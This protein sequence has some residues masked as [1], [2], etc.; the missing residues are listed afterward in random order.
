MDSGSDTSNIQTYVSIIYIGYVI[1]AALSLF[2]KD[3]VGRQWSYRLYTLLWVV[4]QMAAC[5]TPTMRGIIGA[6]TV[7]G[8]GIGS[9][10]V[11]GPMS[12][13]EIS[14]KEIRGLLTS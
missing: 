3:N 10:S 7:S 9:R 1:G 4:G 5:F 13:V 6:R 14:P 2:V 11:I 8:M 12:I